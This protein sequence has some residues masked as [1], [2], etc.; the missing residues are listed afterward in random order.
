MHPVMN[1]FELRFRIPTYATPAWVI[2]TVRPLPPTASV[3]CAAA[4]AMV[5]GDRG[6]VVVPKF[7]TYKTPL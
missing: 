4:V 1:P 6:P 3:V 7:G 5:K 2:S